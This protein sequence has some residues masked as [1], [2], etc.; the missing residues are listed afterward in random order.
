MELTLTNNFLSE[1]PVNA[2]ANLNNIK[3]LDLGSNRIQVNNNN[4][5]HT[6]VKEFLFKKYK[7]VKPWL[8]KIFRQPIS[9]NS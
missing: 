7:D 2:L 3:M 9:E 6:I 1:V 5:N 8:Q 4:L